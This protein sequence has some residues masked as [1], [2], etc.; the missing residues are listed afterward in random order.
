MPANTPKILAF[1]GSLR[2]ASFNHRLVQ[3][4]A[5][6][7]RDAG[8]DVTLIRLRDFPLPIYDGDGEAASG[9]PAEAKRLKELMKASHGLLI[10]A[11]EYNSSLPAALKNAI[12]WASRPEEGEP[13]LAAFRGKVAGLVAASPGG[14]GGLRGLFHLREILQ[15]IGV[16]VV[17]EQRAV[18]GAHEAFAADGSLKDE[19]LNQAVRGVGARLAE[20][21]RAVGDASAAS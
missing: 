6:G 7:A 16:T 2:E 12:D 14:L 9:I 17:P 11:P 10:S 1:G 20:V 19:E 8:A 3:V 21:A 5:E 4:A 15:N 18:S 13:R